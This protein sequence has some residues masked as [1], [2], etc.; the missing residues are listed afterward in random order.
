MLIDGVLRRGTVNWNR[1]LNDITF[2]DSQT[3]MLIARPWRGLGQPRPGFSGMR[4]PEASRAPRRPGPGGR[5]SRPQPPRRIAA[6]TYR[7]SVPPY[8]GIRFG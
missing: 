2:L 3:A 6:Y 8:L 4:D 5:Q 7:G 1:E